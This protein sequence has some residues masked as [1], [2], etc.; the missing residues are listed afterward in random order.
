MHK[1]ELKNGVL[2]YLAV[3]DKNF[4]IIGDE[5][6]NKVVPTDFWETTKEKMSG[7]FQEGKFTEG[8]S[9]GIE[10]AGTHLKKYFPYHPS[11]TNELTNEL[12]LGSK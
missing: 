5:G 8:L 7:H 11:D 12:S 4:A 6:I 9:E 3:K 2:I 1:T 10:S